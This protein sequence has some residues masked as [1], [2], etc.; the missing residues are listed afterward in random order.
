M[1]APEGT[2]APGTEGDGDVLRGTVAGPL[3]AGA[4]GFASGM[5]GAGA[6][7]GPPSC[8]GA[9]F[10]GMVGAGDG[11][12]GGPLGAGGAGAVFIGAG[13]GGAG[14]PAAVGGAGDRGAGGLPAAVGGAGGEGGSED[15]EVFFIGVGGLV[16][17]FSS[18][19]IKSE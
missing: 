7:G 13:E 15:S 17:S 16:F 2:E 5:V 1:G 3:G 18:A 14:A 12:L 10:N 8:E 6:L 4:P 11:G 19:I 9:V